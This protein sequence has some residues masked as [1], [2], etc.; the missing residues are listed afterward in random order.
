MIALLGRAHL[1][2]GA[3][4]MT[5]MVTTARYGSRPRVAVRR[6]R[7]RTSADRDARGF[8]AIC[9]AAES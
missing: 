9:G 5:S 3:F 8:G 4:P 6:R 7:G 1:P 2:T